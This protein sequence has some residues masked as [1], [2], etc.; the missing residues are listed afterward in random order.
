MEM[1]LSGV[2]SQIHGMGLELVSSMARSGTFN[3]A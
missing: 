2:G 1:L 3:E